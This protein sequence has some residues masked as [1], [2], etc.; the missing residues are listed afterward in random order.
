MTN[1]LARIM[2][3]DTMEEAPMGEQ[4]EI[5][6]SG[7]QVFLGYWKNEDATDAVFLELGGVDG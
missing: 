7:P 6:V 2:D 3:I 5:L 1:T 4:G